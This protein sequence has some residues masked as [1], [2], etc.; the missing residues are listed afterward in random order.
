M[1]IAKPPHGGKLGLIG[2]ALT[3]QRSNPHTMAALSSARDELEAVILNSEYL[4]EAPFSWVTVA[5]RYGSKNDDESK[6]QRIDIKYGDLPLSIEIDTHQTIE[7]SQLD[8]ELLFKKYG[9]KALVH[10]GEKY[11]LIVDS[12]KNTLNELR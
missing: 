5:V 12:L 4:E 1:P 6:Y 7:I 3:Q 9:L 10:A 11:G 8:L 2:I